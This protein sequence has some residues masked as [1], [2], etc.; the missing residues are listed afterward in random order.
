MP[1]R[2]RSRDPRRAMQVASR[3]RRATTHPPRSTVVSRSFAAAPSFC[4]CGPSGSLQ[5]GCS[6]GQ[7]RLRTGKRAIAEGRRDSDP[8]HLRNATSKSLPKRP[9]QSQTE[10]VRWRQRWCPLFMKMD[11]RTGATERYV[12][13]GRRWNPEALS[14]FQKLAVFTCSRSPVRIAILHVLDLMEAVMSDVVRFLQSQRTTSWTALTATCLTWL[15]CSIVR[16]QTLKQTKNKQTNPNPK[17][18]KN[19]NPPKKPNPPPS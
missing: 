10:A 7:T 1:R 9:G 19:Q 2:V 14:L 17:T 3:L 4:R 13:T 8:Q 18:H 16:D 15:I 11:P 12:E 6:A 5:T